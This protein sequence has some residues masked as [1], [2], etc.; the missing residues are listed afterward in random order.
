M[1]KIPKE[2]RWGASLWRIVTERGEEIVFDQISGD[3]VFIVRPAGRDRVYDFHGFPN[4]KFRIGYFFRLVPGHEFQL[5]DITPDELGHV[6][7]PE[8][9]IGM[10]ISWVENERAIYSTSIVKEIGP[11]SDWTRGWVEARIE[12][13]RIDRSGKSER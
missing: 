3:I 12:G 8:K 4:P 5:V 10:S 11:V 7:A 9:V 6:V 2:K 13:R 1:K